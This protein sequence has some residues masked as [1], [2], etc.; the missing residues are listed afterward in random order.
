LAGRR[1]KYPCL[2]CGASLQLCLCDIMPRIEVPTK[3]SLIIHHRELSRSSN[4][5]MLAMRALVNSEMRIR[6]ADREVLDLQDLLTPR[7]RT[8]LF[9]PSADA[10][11]L[12][13]ELIAQDARPIQLLVPDGTWRQT[14]KIHS[15]H[16]ELNEVQ[17]VKI[18][19]PNE[20]I[21]Q[22]RGQSRA[23]GMATLQAIAMS[24]GI[25]EGEHIAAAL[26]K[27]YQAKVRRT[28]AGRGLSLEER[29]LLD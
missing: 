16:P 29:W 25:I 13:R 12:T 14:R 11:E 18:S 22:L 21:Y 27:L 17:R 24:L 15:R 20:S 8:F 9:Y 2:G 4:T 10:V 26:M 1:I 6:G 23:E 19:T 7:Y 28:L 5:G 3:I